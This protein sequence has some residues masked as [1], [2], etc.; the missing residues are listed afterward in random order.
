[1][2]QPESYEELADLR[3]VMAMTAMSRS[4]V[5]LEMKNADR[6]F[7]KPLK[8]GGRSVWVVSEVQAWIRATIVA[9]PRMGS[10]VGS[11]SLSNKKPL[12]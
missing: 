9:L 1:M 5:Y 12:K 10:G 6:P 8:L 11:A 2:G 3:R 4:R 7:P